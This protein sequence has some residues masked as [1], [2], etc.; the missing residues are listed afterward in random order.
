MTDRPCLAEEV[1]ALA[2]GWIGTPYRHQ[3][4]LKGVGSDCLGL[5]RG[6]WRT[7]YGRETE[8]IPPYT[9]DWSEASGTETLLEGAARHL[10]AVPGASMQAGDV[11]I[12]RMRQG[13]VAK[14]VGILAGDPG[15]WTLIHAYSGRAVCESVLG[16]A[17]QRR[18]AGVFRFPAPCRRLAR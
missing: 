17:W 10:M 8:A 9:P 7:V 18:I 11:L 15:A 1:V 2:R 13:G 5:L 14:H 6:I 3:A 16:P 12:F 4:S